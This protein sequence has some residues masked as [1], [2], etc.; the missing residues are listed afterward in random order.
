M[1]MV[2][3]IS[4]KCPMGMATTSGTGIGS[5]EKVSPKIVDTLVGINKSLLN[6]IAGVPSLEGLS[7]NMT[8]TPMVYISSVNEIPIIEA[9]ASASLPRTAR[10]TGKPIKPL[11]GKATQIA[12]VPRRFLETRKIYAAARD[13][14]VSPRYRPRPSA[15]TTRLSWRNSA[16]NGRSRE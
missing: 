15:A 8:R 3:A 16:S 14:P 4:A 13:R 1:D 10:I 7:D 12:Q 11:F 2:V 9:S 5:R 6:P